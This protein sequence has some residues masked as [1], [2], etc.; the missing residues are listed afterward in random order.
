MYDIICALKSSG[1]NLKKYFLK[2]DP[3]YFRIEQV[4]LT[5]YMFSAIFLTII[6]NATNNS[7]SLTV[8]KIIQGEFLS[9][10]ESIFI[11]FIIVVF[12]V[13]ITI[14]KMI[15]PKKKIKK[16]NQTDINKI[17]DN[18]EML[19]ALKSFAKTEWSIEN[20]LFLLEVI[21]YKSISNS[22]IKLIAA[23]NIYTTFIKVNALIE[24]NFPGHLKNEILPIRNKVEYHWENG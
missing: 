18:K 10:Y 23:K 12:P 19:N 16:I 22:K 21:K 2:S 24:V 11:L 6:G 13:S 9:G 5:V 4:I 3:Y 1:F 17:L 8:S 20:V 15:K 14:F 7:K